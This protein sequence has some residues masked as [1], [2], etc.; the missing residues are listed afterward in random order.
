MK[1]CKKCFKV[2][3]K[4]EFPV[5]GTCKVCHKKQK[6]IKELGKSKPVEVKVDGPKASTKHTKSQDKGNNKKGIRQWL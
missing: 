3:P 4:E 6:A 1:E 5:D 2:K